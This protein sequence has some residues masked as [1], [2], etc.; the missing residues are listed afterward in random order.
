MDWNK[1]FQ[2]LYRS[3][4]LT[5]VTAGALKVVNVLGEAGV[6]GF[7]SLMEKTDEAAYNIASQSWAPT[8][9][10]ID[11]SK[12]GTYRGGDWLGD[13]EI[14]EEGPD[15][16]GMY[17]GRE[18]NVL[19]ES[20]YKPTSWTRPEPEQ[21]WRSIKE[22]SEFKILDPSDAASNLSMKDQEVFSRHM[23]AD[24]GDPVNKMM[25][26]VEMGEYD[27]SYAVGFSGGTV[28]P[29]RYSTDINLGSFTRSLGYDPEKEQY[30]Y[31]IAD[32]WDFEPELYT[33]KWGGFRGKEA[34]LQSKAGGLRETYTQASLMEAAGKPIGIYD[35]YYLPEGTLEGFGF[36]GSMED[37][38]ID[39]FTKKE[40][41]Y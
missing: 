34:S 13:I 20:E 19:P 10:D 28:N 3:E 26:A 16:L 30:Y 9:E 32:V 18:E 24:I 33:E 2:Y 29:F 27:P 41:I 25:R 17:L 4:G 35:R 39:Q 22:H 6:P 21:G 23:M 37:K 7:E 1:Y 31:S 11:P 14:E 8:R 36:G 40:S 5:D 15:I 38:L 12:K